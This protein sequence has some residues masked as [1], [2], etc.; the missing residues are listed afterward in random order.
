MKEIERKSI[1]LSG[2][3]IPLTY[4]LILDQFGNEQGW[5]NMM[6]LSWTCTA[7]T[8]TLDLLRV[9]IPYLNKHWWWQDKLRPFEKKPTYWYVL[10]FPWSH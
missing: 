10:L 4:Q 1:H 9:N 7:I 5:I 2:V 3:L 8:W 6:K